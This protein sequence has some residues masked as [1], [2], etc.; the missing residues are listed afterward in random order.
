[1]H[2][3]NPE[4]LTG[5]LATIHS[6]HQRD[7]IALANRADTFARNAALGGPWTDTPG[8]DALADLHPHI[9]TAAV[10]D[11]IRHAARSQP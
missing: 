10:T 3:R 9:T 11:P 1:M 6:A 5:F 7:L 2:F 4:A 8:A